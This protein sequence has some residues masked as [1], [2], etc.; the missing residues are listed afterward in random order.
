MA[1]Y[2]MYDRCCCVFVFSVTETRNCN[3]RRG[4]LLGRRAHLA[5]SALG[6]QGYPALGPPT[7]LRRSGSSSI[8]P[9]SP[10][11]SSWVRSC[12]AQINSVL[13]KVLPEFF[14]RTHDPTTVNRQ[15]PKNVGSRT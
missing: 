2:E 11:A 4:V 10:T 3:I 1:W 6:E 8:R 14:Y 15:G 9:L 12:S 5:L 13:M 7:T